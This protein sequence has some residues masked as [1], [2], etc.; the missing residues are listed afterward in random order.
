MVHLNLYGV[1]MSKKSLSSKDAVERA[2]Q[3]LAEAK[4]D[5]YTRQDALSFK[6]YLIAKGFSVYSFI[7]SSEI[8]LRALS[9]HQRMFR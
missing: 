1:K 9:T 3:Y 4:A 6:D 8:R 2:C 5:E 7:K